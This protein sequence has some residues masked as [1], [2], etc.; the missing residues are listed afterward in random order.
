MIEPKEIEIDGKTFIISKFPAIA[1]REIITQY[2]PSAA[3]KIGDYKNNE[4]LM[5]KLMS[6]VGVTIA[7]GNIVQLSTQALVN[8]HV[9]SW[10]TL[11]K[12]EAA[13]LEYNCS[14]FQNGLISGF[15]GDIAQKLPQWISKILTDSLA[16]LSQKEKQPSTNFEQSTV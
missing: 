12:L 4:A 10:E 9:G 5:L 1:G 13:M 3:P 6:Y 7:S 11:M 2:L 14:F 16:Q 8:N 15:F